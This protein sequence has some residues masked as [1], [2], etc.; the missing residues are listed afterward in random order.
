MLEK[1]EIGK[2][3]TNK[4]QDEFTVI[5]VG[6]TMVV[7]IDNIDGECAGYLE[8]ALKYWSELPREEEKWFK[9]IY[10]H[11]KNQRPARMKNL[12]KSQEDFLNYTDFKKEDYHWISL[13]EF[14]VE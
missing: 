8:T 4:D 9:V 5:F 6:K 11:K 3:Y 1:I 2:T 7:Y 13:K 10:F 12:F 14:K